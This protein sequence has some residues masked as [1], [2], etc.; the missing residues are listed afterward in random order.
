VEQFGHVLHEV[1]IKAEVD[2]FILEVGQFVV[3]LHQF[4]EFAFQVAVLG[5]DSPQV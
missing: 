3:G 2:D 5:D 4:P 1:L